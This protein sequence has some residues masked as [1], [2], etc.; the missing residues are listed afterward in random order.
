MVTERN[1]KLEYRHGTAKLTSLENTPRNT[2][3]QVVNKQMF[4]LF[5]GN[6]NRDHDGE[7]E[8]RTEDDFLV[9]ETFGDETVERETENFT[10]VGGLKKVV[11]IR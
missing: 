1:G 8:E 9:A 2:G 5:G 7:Y 4:D 10:A 11:S 6:G 3:D